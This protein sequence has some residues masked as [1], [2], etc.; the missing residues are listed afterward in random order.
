MTKCP[1]CTCVLDTNDYSARSGHVTIT[2]DA[3]FQCVSIPISD[4]NSRESSY[5]C[6]TFHISAVSTINGL[7]VEPSEAN[8]CII[9]RDCE[10]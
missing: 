6:F 9:D 5:E 1:F 3:Q 4:D 8:V 7:S 10:L 2:D